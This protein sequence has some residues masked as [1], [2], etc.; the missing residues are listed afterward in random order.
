MKSTITVTNST[1]Q[2]TFEPETPYETLIVKQ[3]RE[4][5]STE[6]FIDYNGGDIPIMKLTV[7]E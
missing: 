3:L 4:T 1:V 6:H 2:L 5:K 7:K